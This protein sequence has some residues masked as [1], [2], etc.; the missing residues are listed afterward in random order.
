MKFN[1]DAEQARRFMAAVFG[2]LPHHFS[3]TLDRDKNADWF[4]VCGTLDECLPVLNRQSEWGSSI[5][6]PVNDIRGISK[7]A[8]DILNIVAIYAE[9]DHGTHKP[10][11]DPT[12]KVESSPGR[13]HY[14]YLLTEPQ[15][16]SAGIW[17]NIQ[18]FFVSQRG[19][20]I[21]AKNLERE[22]R[23]PGSWH[24]KDPNKPFQVRIVSES[25]KRYTVDD[26]L[27]VLVWET[28]DEHVTWSCDLADE[29]A[30]VLL[31]KSKEALKTLDPDC[32]R[33]EWIQYGMAL[34]LI[35]PA[36]GFVIWDNWSRQGRKYSERVT[37]YQWESFRK[38]GGN[39]VTYRSILEDAC[40]QGWRDPVPDYRPPAEIN[41]NGNVVIPP[42]KLLGGQLPEIIRQAEQALID[43]GIE[44]YQRG[45]QL[46]RPAK[47]STFEAGRKT[48]T[49]EL[50]DVSALWLLKTLTE[51]VQFTRYDGRKK[52]WIP[53]DCPKLVCDT[54]LEMGG[55]WRVPPIVGISECPTIRI[56]DGTLIN[57]PGYDHE[58][59]VYVDCEPVKMPEC[60]SRED[61]LKAV[62]ILKEP[63]REFPFV[64]QSDLAVVLAAILTG[65]VR[66]S[67]PTSPM[68][69]FDA[70]KAGS[71]KGLLAD[72]IALI[73]TGRTATIVSQGAD[74]AEDEKRIGSL[75]KQ[76]TS[77][78]NLDNVE[79]QIRGDFLCSALS[80]S[81][82][83]T[84]ILGLS[85][86]VDLH[87]NSLFLATGNNL[88]V[89]TDIARRVLL[90]QVDP[91][92][93]R[94]DSRQFSRDLRQWV[95]ANRERLLAAG[96]TILRAFI[97]AGRPKQDIRPYG[98]YETWSEVVRSP[99]VWL[100]L[101]D[102]CDTR[103][104]LQ[105]ADPVSGQLS[106][107]L[108]L[109]HDEFKTPK[110][111]G[112]V[113]ASCQASP[114][115][116]ALLEVAASRTGDA[117]DGRRLGGWLRKHARR[118]EAGL[119]FEAFGLDSHT[120]TQLWASVKVAG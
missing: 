92:C 20:D 32:G 15:P 65:I 69:C 25:S 43:A 17:R 105:A 46:V 113:I 38:E 84:R 101:S 114:L 103:E 14:W 97:L 19:G 21:N 55:H 119:R 29:E 4:S 76:S 34:K 41:E 102:P 106:T 23:L 67:L 63:F 51:T 100:G 75:L 107:I 72:A 48:T 57:D 37:R 85:K 117:L 79:R 66:K 53:T 88:S 112:D 99:L 56:E 73:V 64:N 83:G 49:T 120:K 50:A 13:Y 39:V 62:E 104:R 9:D 58:S 22:L 87:T 116:A 3:Y 12:F 68:F 71:G 11:F 86:M 91:C 5:H 110:T 30:E 16:G 42:I 109:W 26:F 93:E 28:P 31:K 115:K 6:I 96:L 1:I 80:Q 54:F 70:P 78:I 118:V 81:K 2:D 33:T 35:H 111:V 18:R 95:P 27:D 90:C 44:V 77:V 98:T 74:D 89:S 60:V 47:F 82:V 45:K 59:G 10:P 7:K 94:P 52:A 61:A 36:D 108:Q 24:R 8:E 40:R